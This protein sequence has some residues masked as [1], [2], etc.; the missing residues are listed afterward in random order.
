[1]NLTV[2]VVT[3]IV[4]WL[5][6]T[7]GLAYGDA[8]RLGVHRA[9]ALR[10]A[11]SALVR[12]H[13]YWHQERL[14]YLSPAERAQLQRQEAQRLGLQG[15]ANMRCPLCSAEIAQAWSLD[16]TGRL[17][18]CRRPVSCPQCDFRLD[19]CRHCAHFKAESGLMYGDDW[20]RGSCTVYKTM[21]PVEAF[22]PPSVAQELQERGY[23]HLPAPTPI[24]DSYVPLENCTAFV[25]DEH[26]LKVNGV[27]LPG[28][29]QRG[30][31]DKATQDAALSATGEHSGG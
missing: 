4:L 31:L 2:W 10:L 15:V 24:V 12:P 30:L 27:R 19:S 25:L 23:T 21:Q 29:R 18:V 20:T 6:L 1:M 22:C 17:T 11:F 26:R 13:V 7:G 14:Y 5:A 16:R 9:P 8:R 28:L 3:L